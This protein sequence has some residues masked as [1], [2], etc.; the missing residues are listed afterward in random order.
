MFCQECGNNL[1]DSVKFCDACGTKIT[2]ESK[3]SEF[4]QQQTPQEEKFTA[5][6]PFQPFSSIDPNQPIYKKTFFKGKQSSTGTRGQIKFDGGKKKSFLK[7]LFILLGALIAIIL[8]LSIFADSNIT[9]VQTATAIA[10]GTMEPMNVA[11]TFNTNTP[12]IFVTFSLSGLPIGTN[13]KGEW[14]YKD[15]DISIVTGNMHTT[16]NNQ[17]A[18]FSLSIPD[19]GWPVGDYEVKLFAGDDYKTSAKFKVE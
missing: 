16:E 14:I 7:R 2:A 18:Y 13:I 17:N 8:V 5:P 4:E 11:T 15:Q 9:K 3:S 19:N 10:S 12:E 1:P 6:E